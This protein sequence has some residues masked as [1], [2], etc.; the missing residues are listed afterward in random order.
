MFKSELFNV[1]DHE[2]NGPEEK[3]GKLCT[4]ITVSSF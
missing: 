4:G 2:S 1:T 3:K